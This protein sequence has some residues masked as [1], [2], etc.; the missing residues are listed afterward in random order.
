M[1]EEA[2]RT[3]AGSL[4]RYTMCH[5]T[6]HRRTTCGTSIWLSVLVAL[7]SSWLPSCAAPRRGVTTLTEEDKSYRFLVDR[8]ANSSG[9]IHRQIIV[10]KPRNPAPKTYL[11]ET[12]GLLMRYQVTIDDRRNFERQ[13]QLITDLFLDG[14]GLMQWRV[15]VPPREERRC[16]ASLD[17]LRVAEALLLGYE[18]WGHRRYLWLALRLSAELLTK[19]LVGDYFVEAYCWGQVPQKATI[20]D[21][22]YLKLSAM[23][24]LSHY[25][26]RWRRIYQTSRE[27]LTAAK[28]PSGFFWDKFD[29]LTRRYAIQD[30]NLINNLL[31]AINL[32]EVGEFNN[33]VLAYLREE[34]RLREKVYG[35]YDPVTLKPLARFESIAVY[36][37]L[38]R[39]ALLHADEAFATALFERI[40]RFQINN[41]A[42]YFNGAFADD[43]AHSFDQLMCL[44][45]IS[46]YR[47]MR[48]KQRRTPAMPPLRLQTRYP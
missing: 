22:S 43:V 13:F 2:R 27:V 4:D 38:M 25:D 45:A 3:G 46:S 11:S 35:R 7:L 26:P 39:L 44:L 42:S 32:A 15:T 47:A 19:N 28:L 8:M 48:A 14:Q 23:K 21:L 40:K 6:S 17:D 29:P 1:G 9:G 5:E 20:V 41:E 36:A 12:V 10:K 30:A 16:N 34:W 18:R 33:E 24:K 37:L 31:C